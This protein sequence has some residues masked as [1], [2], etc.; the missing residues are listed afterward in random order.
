MDGVKK[1]AAYLHHVGEAKVSN[2]DIEVCVEQK[3]LGFQIPECWCRRIQTDLRTSSP[4][5]HIVPVAV[6]H[7]GDDLLKEPAGVLKS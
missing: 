4:V 3:I 1:T 6:V 5:Y 2:L 7:S